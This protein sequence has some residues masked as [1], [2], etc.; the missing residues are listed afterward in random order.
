MSV[1]SFEEAQKKLEKASDSDAQ[2]TPSTVL[3]F[4]G[5]LPTETEEDR[6]G[7]LA[8]KVLSRSHFEGFTTKSD[9]ARDHADIVAMLACVGF[10]STQIGSYQW[11]NLWKITADGLTFLQDSLEGEMNE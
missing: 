4:L 10:I 5:Q 6:D 3:E 8:Y 2:L 1:I 11:S 7:I 9:Y